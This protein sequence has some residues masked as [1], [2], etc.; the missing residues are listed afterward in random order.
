M[1]GSRRVKLFLGVGAVLYGLL[2]LLV[3]YLQPYGDSQAP[4]QWL[5]LHPGFPESSPPYILAFG[6]PILGIAVGAIVDA[7]HPNVAA[8]VLLWLATAVFLVETGLTM[9]SIGLFLLPAFVAGFCASLLA[10]T[11]SR[12]TPQRA[13]G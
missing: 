1:S 3:V 7:T 11:E 9:A 6:L 4:G 8:R 12:P 5:T 13:G 10:F 2:L